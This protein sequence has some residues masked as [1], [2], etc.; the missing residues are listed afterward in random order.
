M[1]TIRFLLYSNVYLLLHEQLARTVPEQ[2]V[3]ADL[4]FEGLDAPLVEDLVVLMVD[5][6]G[7]LLGL[8]GGADDV[9]QVYILESLGLSDFI[10]CIF[11]E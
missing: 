10:I 5:E 11:Q 8:V 1:D 6:G 7:L 3:E 2:L 9:A 4:H